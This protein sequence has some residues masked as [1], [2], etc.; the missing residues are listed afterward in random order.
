MSVETVSWAYEQPIDNALRK[1]VLVCLC[2]HASSDGENCYPGQELISLETGLKERALRNHLKALEDAGIIRREK[3]YG[4][5]G[6][7]RDFDRWILIGYP[8]WVAERRA[9]RRER[10]AQAADATKLPASGAGSATKL[11]ASNGAGSATKLPASDDRATG[12]FGGGLPASDDSATIWEQEEQDRTRV[13]RDGSPAGGPA[14]AR[15]ESVP[16]ELCPTL[17]AKWRAVLPTLRD[18]VQPEH[19]EHWLERLVP[20]QE[21]AEWFALA[22]ANPAIATGVKLNYGSLL[23]KALGTPEVV[24]VHRFWVVKHWTAERRRAAAR[25][26]KVETS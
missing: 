22:A 16:P 9:E 12:T 20:L 1:A 3:R 23:A 8:E 11:P 13:A 26:G 14:D 7:P 2:H 18:Q 17:I 21:T 6:K 25:A 10:M 19:Y 4:A 15:D 5:D 24:V